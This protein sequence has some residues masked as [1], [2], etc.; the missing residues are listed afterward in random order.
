MMK[1]EVKCRHLLTGFC[2]SVKNKFGGLV[3]K[4]VGNS[5]LNKNTHGITRIV[6]L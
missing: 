6:I 4:A 3:S 5:L 1:Q 2:G